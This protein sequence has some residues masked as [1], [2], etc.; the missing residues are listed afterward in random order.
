MTKEYDVFI[1]HASED[2]REVALPLAKALR[3]VGLSV[4]LDDAELKLGDNLNEKIFDGLG[5]SS[6]GV[7]ILSHAFFR[8]QWPTSELRALMAR[9]EAG[10]KVLLP[11][12]YQITQQEL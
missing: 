10:S 3:N 1:S 12:R 8:K 4:W 2:K 11:I 5:K 9:E 6:F 7:V